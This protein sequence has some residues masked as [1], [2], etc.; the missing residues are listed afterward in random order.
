MKSQ[1]TG[2]EGFTMS[3]SLHNS[4]EPHI[5]A[6]HR[7]EVDYQRLAATD[8]KQQLQKLVEWLRVTSHT[9][10]RARDH[11]TLSTPIGGKGRAGPSSLH[12]TLEGPTEYV[13]AWWM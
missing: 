13:N 3:N 6:V 4:Q 7:S 9:T 2:T 1:L 10:L 8:W 5:N 11:Y 12:T